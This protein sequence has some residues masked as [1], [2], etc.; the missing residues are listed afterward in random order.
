MRIV[1]YKVGVFKIEYIVKT[2]NNEV[3]TYKLSK[4]MSPLKARRKL[5]NLAGESKDIK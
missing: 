1:G 2:D 3:F 5:K 4:N